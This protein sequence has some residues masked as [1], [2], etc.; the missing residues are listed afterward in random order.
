MRSRTVS[1]IPA[2]VTSSN[3]P[4]LKV[5]GASNRNVT[6]L[7]L[8]VDLHGVQPKVW[9]RILVPASI[10]LRKLH[11]VLLR[12]MG[13]EG[14]H[15]HEFEFVDGSYG[16]PDPDW[17]DEALSDESRVTLNKALGGT[18]RFTWTYDLGD[19]WTHRITVERVAAMPAEF[20]LKFPICLAGAGAC[21]PEDVGGKFG[22]EEFLMAIADPSH[23][24]HDQMKA[25]IGRPFDP[26]AFAV[27]EAQ[28]RL[29]EIEV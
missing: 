12:A 1:T 16:V 9:R 23:P 11:V 18:S 13:W 20:K 6:V 10:R 8:K 14:E 19:A 2:M 21:P 17:P 24:E 4:S 15:M 3:R 26:K 29:Y 27:Q 7:Q 5:V 25:W 28:E 22:Y